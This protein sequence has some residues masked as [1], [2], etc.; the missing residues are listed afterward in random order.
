MTPFYMKNKALF[1]DQNQAEKQLHKKEN[2]L[3]TTKNLG[4]HTTFSERNCSK[5]ILR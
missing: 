4:D 3:E 2:Y 1:S 5:Y